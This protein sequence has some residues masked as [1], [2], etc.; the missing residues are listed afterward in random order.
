MGD[1]K[2]HRGTSLILSGHLPLAEQGQSLAQG[3]LTTRCLVWE[4]IELIPDRGQFEAGQHG[5]ERLM[6]DH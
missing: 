4:A 1:G 2:A 3:E 5:Q 6:V